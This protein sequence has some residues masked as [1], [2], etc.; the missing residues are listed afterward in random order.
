MSFFDWLWHSIAVAPSPW[1]YAGGWLLAV[2]LVVLVWVFVGRK[3]NVSLGEEEITAPEP[4]PVVP[5]GVTTHTEFRYT[6]MDEWYPLREFTE[7]VDATA[8]A[9]E[10][11][12][13]V[14]DCSETVEIKPVDPLD[15]TA[16]LETV[17]PSVPLFYTLRRP[18]PYVAE[19]FTQGIQRA[20]IERALE[21]GRPQ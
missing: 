9:T 7:A 16:E 12:A 19:S 8:D 18:R 4:Q 15:V 2:G 14:I 1:V 6:V 21:A 10:E 3:G 20:Q 13:R 17:D 11:L 5:L